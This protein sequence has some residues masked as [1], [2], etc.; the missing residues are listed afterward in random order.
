M[1]AGGYLVLCALLC[2]VPLA[3]VSAQVRYYSSNKTGMAINEIS[4]SSCPLERYYLVVQSEPLFELRSLRGPD[5]KEVRH[6]EY[7]LNSRGHPKKIDFYEGPHLSSSED[8]DESDHLI[9]Y[10]EYVDAAISLERRFAYKGGRLSG[11]DDYDAQGNLLVSM[12]YRYGMRG[13]L[14]EYQEKQGDSLL[15]AGYP[16]NYS[17]YSVQKTLKDGMATLSLRYQSQFGLA[18]YSETIQGDEQ[19]SLAELGENAVSTK[20]RLSD[21]SER[22][23]LSSREGLLLEESIQKDGK[24]SYKARY[25][26]EAG[27]L[28]TVSIREN[29]L[30]KRQ[31]YRYQGTRLSEHLFY[32]GERLQRRL[33]YS[34]DDEYIE[35]V[36][37]RDQVAIRCTYRD[38]RR[39]LEE[40]YQ[41]GRLIRQVGSIQ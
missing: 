13:E 14:R 30:D 16:N 4:L 18:E 7:R 28:K 19:T 33:E 32:V 2:L 20:E 8:Y 35:E 38:G 3:A 36:F 23:R 15:A 9:L 22:T 12:V 17:R 21:G 29:G 41:D 1:R 6:W 31:E 24:L 27:R 39:C 26:Y 25:Q 37:D 34:S 5:G 40:Y 10:R 11:W